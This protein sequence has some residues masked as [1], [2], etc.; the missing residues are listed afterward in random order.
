MLMKID[1]IQMFFSCYREIFCPKN[2]QSDIPY[3]LFDG[4]IKFEF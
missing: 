3:I 4:Y 1:G 2:L